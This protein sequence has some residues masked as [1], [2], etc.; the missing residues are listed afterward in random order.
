MES[1]TPREVHETPSSARNVS[2]PPPPSSAAAA[3]VEK[4]RSLPALS[5]RKLL[6]PERDAGERDSKERLVEENEKIL[7]EYDEILQLF[8]TEIDR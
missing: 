2:A 1:E 6:K 4:G 8:S 5:W 3:L 7:G